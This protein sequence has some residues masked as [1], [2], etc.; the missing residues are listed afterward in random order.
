M[1]V[2]LTDLLIFSDLLLTPTPRPT[3]TTRPPDLHLHHPPTSRED[4]RS[5]TLSNNMA[6]PAAW[7]LKGLDDLG[8]EFSVSQVEGVIPA[9]DSFCLQVR[10]KAIKPLHF[11]KTLR[12][13][14]L[15][16]LVCV[17]QAWIQWSSL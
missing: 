15:Y 11:R 10:F 9:R 17:Y 3:S 13:E 5:V 2:L 6:L 8:E 14:V 7:R 12:L 16:S 1:T 4:S